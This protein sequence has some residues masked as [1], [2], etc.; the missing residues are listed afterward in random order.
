MTL[1]IVNLFHESN[2]FIRKVGKTSSTLATSDDKFYTH[3]R[4]NSFL[5]VRGQFRSLFSKNS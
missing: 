1:A 4:G 2:L 5:T 3:D